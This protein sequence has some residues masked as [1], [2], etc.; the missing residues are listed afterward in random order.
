MLKPALLSLALLASP[1]FA[2]SHYHAEPTAKPAAAKLVLRDTI[3]NCGDGGCAAARSNSRP[4][5]VCAVLVKKV[6]ALRSFSVGGTSLS[7]EDLEKCN[8]R[9]D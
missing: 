9:G 5:I 4:A 1:A 3:W 2:S 6:G 7:A 8:A